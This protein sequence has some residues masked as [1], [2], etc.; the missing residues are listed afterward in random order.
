MI[1]AIDGPT[2]SGKGTI[3]KAVAEH[4]SLPCLDT[5]L[6]YRGVAL[7][8]LNNGKDLT[9]ALAARDAALTL[10]LAVLDPETLRTAAVGAGASVVAA[11]PEVRAALLDYQRGFAAQAGGA[12]LDGRDIA[13]VIAPQAE[14]KIFVT[15]T[16]EERAKR[17]QAELEKRGE[18]VSFETM[19][20]QIQE[21]DARDSGRKDAPLAMAPD[22]ILLDTTTLS[23]DAAIA[24]ARAVVARARI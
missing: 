21:R 23:I 16:A 20:A 4:F 5:G 7:A 22:A 9:D 15:A 8:L 3:A 11:I 10:N 2:A 17:R 6:L 19:L 14:V 12:V 24:E 18:A 1:V 13:T